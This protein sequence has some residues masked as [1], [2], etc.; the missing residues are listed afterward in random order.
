MEDVDADPWAD[1][2]SMWSKPFMPNL[3]N[4][5]VFLVETSQLVAV[6]FVN[7]KGRPWMKGLTENHGELH[8]KTHNKIFENA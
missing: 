3:M 5:V 4:T 2:L 7:Y 6:L 1:I 8:S